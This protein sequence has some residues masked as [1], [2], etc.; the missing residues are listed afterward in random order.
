VGEVGQ[1]FDCTIIAIWSREMIGMMM[2]VSIHFDKGPVLNDTTAFGL[3][4]LIFM[5]TFLPIAVYYR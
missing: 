4:Q 1:R 3:R 2:A 5:A